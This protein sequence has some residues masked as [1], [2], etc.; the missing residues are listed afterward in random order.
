MAT[1][2]KMVSGHGTTAKSQRAGKSGQECN[3]Q[4]Q[5]VRGCAC[6]DFG[7]RLLQRSERR[8]EP[9]D[10]NDA[11]NAE[12]QHCCRSLP[13]VP[14]AQKKCQRGR[15]NG[16]HQ[17]RNQH[18]P[19]DDSGAVFEEPEKGD[20][21]SESKERH[22]LDVDLARI[23]N[24]FVD[25][26]L[27]LSRDAKFSAPKQHPLACGMKTMFSG[28]EQPL[29][30]RCR[31]RSCSPAQRMFWSGCLLGEQ[32]IQPAEKEPAQSTVD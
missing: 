2:G 5:Q 22:V 24:G 6:Q 19:N 32:I 26:V 15:E 30:A 20:E 18:R 17:R 29:R 16:V 11:C 31:I 1:P 27:L 12:C 21:S 13:Q 3:E 14:V 25:G 4:I 9:G 8:H 23:Q 28:N 7:C 10:A